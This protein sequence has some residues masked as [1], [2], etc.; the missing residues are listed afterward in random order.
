MVSGGGDSM[1]LLALVHG[2]KADLGLEEIQV[3]TVDHGL[4]EQS[5]LECA[6]VADICADLGVVCTKREWTDHPKSGNLSAAGRHARYGFAKH[7]A[8]ENDL[9]AVAT[10]HTRT[11][12][13]E[14][15][16]MRLARGS[17]VDGLAG[18]SARKEVEG[19]V[20]LRPL[21]DHSR[22]ELRDFLRS[23][24]LDWVD[25]PS[26]DDE[27][28]HRIQI[29]NALPSLEA[30]G[31][32]EERLVET[33]RHMDRA[34]LALE[35]GARDLARNIA[36]PT[37]LGSIK[38]EAKG[39]FAAPQE[40]R[41]RLFA[42]ALFWVTGEV[43]RPRYATLLDALENLKQGRGATL[44]GAFC[45]KKSE[46]IHIMREP[47]AVENLVVDGNWDSRWR[48]SLDGAQTMPLNE[49]A[50][51]FFPNWRESALPKE[52]WMS[53]PGYIDDG[54]LHPF[55]FQDSTSK[56]SCELT[57]SAESFFDL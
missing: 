48:I 15:F 31:L 50:L 5:K 54:H 18:M 10:G 8:N 38:I 24:D 37:E 35:V 21:L 26:N 6:M 27:A 44:R 7:W 2:A 14:T 42:H 52:V 49:N 12:Q 55:V 36:T 40:L 23:I 45:K 19:L 51:E 46:F 11:D 56:Y 16:I 53:L 4:R 33:S 43:Y 34:R 20:W 30:L 39:L 41:T 1:A 9:D 13:A 57:R 47:N 22:E 17:G 32:S 28:Y 29:R 3:I 25:D